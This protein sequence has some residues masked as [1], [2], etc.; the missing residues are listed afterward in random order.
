MNRPHLTLIT[1]RATLG[2]SEGS[3]KVEPLITRYVA[4]RLTRRE[5]CRMTARRTRTVL[6]SFAATY[7]QRP[8]KNMSAA[9]IERWMKTR[10]HVA[11]STL[12]YDVVTLRTFIKWLRQEGE[13]RNDPMRTIANPK[14]PRSVPRALTRAEGMALLSVLPD[15]RANA[16]VMLMLGLGLRRSEVAGLQAGDWDQVART[17]RVTGKGGHTRL[18]P[19]PGRVAAALN[20]YRVRMAAGPMIRHH[21]GVRGLSAIRIS[22]LIRDWMLL[23]GIKAAPY[24]GKACHSLRHTLASEVADVEPD[25]RVLQ[26]IL[27]HVSLTSTQIYLRGV[28]SARLRSALEGAA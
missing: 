3:A 8:V 24:D 10:Q 25:L 23:A 18:L 17:L 4:S 28:E 13:L 9:D 5:I 11:Q 20:R 15:A 6:N 26:Q 27:G 12:R 2:K 1:P 16:I 21:D 14:T 22:A 7:G 19:V